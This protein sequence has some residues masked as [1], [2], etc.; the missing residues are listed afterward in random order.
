MSNVPQGIRDFDH[1]PVSDPIISIVVGSD[2]M[3]ELETPKL[4]NYVVEAD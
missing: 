1:L 2:T 3:D 4:T